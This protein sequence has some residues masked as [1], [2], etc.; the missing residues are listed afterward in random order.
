MKPASLLS[1]VLL[2]VPCALLVLLGVF[3][4]NVNALSVL[5]YDD[6]IVAGPALERPVHP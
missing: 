5:G 3:G 4:C 1:T 6:L 2:A